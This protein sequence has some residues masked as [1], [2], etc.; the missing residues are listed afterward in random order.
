MSNCTT[1]VCRP[2]DRY[3]FCRGLIKVC[4]KC[5]KV[6]LNAR[7][8]CELLK[9]LSAF[10][11]PSSAIVRVNDVED[12]IENHLAQAIGQK[13]EF[14]IGSNRYDMKYFPQFEKILWVRYFKSGPNV[15]DFIKEIRLHLED[16]DIEDIRERLNLLLD[17][18]DKGER[19]VLKEC[20]EF[21]AQV[22]N[23]S[24]KVG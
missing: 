20:K 21:V 1:C 23:A 6:E 15:I 9:V 8:T 10:L 16:L 4:D 24:Q 5:I 11:S 18:I 13:N 14:V 12:S 19:Y 2:C 17:F 7:S 3:L 22:V